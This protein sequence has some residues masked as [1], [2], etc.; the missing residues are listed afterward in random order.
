MAKKHFDEFFED[1]RNQ[2]EETVVIS[3]ILTKEVEEGKADISRVEQFMENSQSIIDL[4]H[5]T[6][7]IRL[8]LDR[9]VK[10][11]KQSAY[12]RRMQKEFEKSI[13]MQL[14]K[15]QEENESSLERLRDLIE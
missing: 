7:N 15:L 9:P 2:F 12:D 6:N 14:S 5:I 11:S 3:R 8:M 4:F 1:I 13:H 10:K